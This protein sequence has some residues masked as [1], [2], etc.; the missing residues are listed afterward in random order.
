MICVRLKGVHW[1]TKRLADGSV[2]RYF[3][4]WPGGPRLAGEPG[5]PEFMA[6]YNAAH[7]ARR[8]PPAG[9]LHRVIADFKVSDEIGNLAD[10]TRKDYLR[11]IATIEKEFASLPIE[12]LDDP[13]VNRMLLSWRNSLAC[14]DRWADYHYTV[15]TRILSW[16]RD[17][18]LTSWRPPARVKKLYHGD[19]S[20][21]IWLPA[22]IAAFRVVCSEQLWLGLVLALETGQR[23][24]DLLALPWSAYDGCWI[25]LRQR[26]TGQ[27]VEIPVTADLKA[28]LDATER[29]SPIIMTSSRGLPWKAHGFSSMWRRATKA[30][31]IDG[32]TFN[33]LRGTAVTRLAE[34]GCTIPQIASLTGHSFKSA[35]QIVERYLP[36]TR[37][38][39]LAAIAKLERGKS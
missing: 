6:S 9:T 22:Q 11:C 14:G 26:K 12:A 18:G 39:A 33:D 28:V 38:L 7:A 4:A 29:V 16:A 35:N 23:Q 21:R 30:A 34:A 17:G 25:K 36:R 3:Y 8:R 37:G 20:E 15:L 1:T 24:G 19:R 5:S 31:A 10:R 27:K 32:L 13:R 2:R